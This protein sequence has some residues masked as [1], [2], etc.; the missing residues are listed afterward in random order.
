MNAVPERPVAGEPGAPPLLLPHVAFPPYR[1]V[2]G[3]APHPFNDREGYGYG[4]R[5]E[6]PP[7]VPRD[8]WRESEPYLRG[9]D[10]FNRGWWWEA[11]ESWESLW[12]VVEG[13][14]EA[15]HE[16]L[17]GL[18][19]LAACALNR[20]RGHDEG[21]AR[22]LET[23]LA[24]LQRA[25]AT[26]GSTRLCGLDLEAVAAEARR[27]LAAPAPRVGPLYLRPS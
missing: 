8:R 17:K 22:L 10:F 13:R 4:Q 6:P 26:A 14:D 2:P 5:P 20:E 9:L 21:A 24:A 12:H 23:A 25:G 18:I 16:L 1:F 3:Q 15:Q 27:A 11:H 7:F 19:Q